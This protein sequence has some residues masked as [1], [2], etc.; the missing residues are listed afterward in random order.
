MMGLVGCLAALWLK[1]LRYPWSRLRQRLCEGRYLKTELPEAKSLQQIRTHLRKVTWT[2]DGFFHLWDALSYPETVWAKKKDDCDGFAVLAAELLERL[3]P[4]LNPVLVT[5]AVRP[6]KR[7]HTVCAFKDGQKFAFFDN[8]RLRKGD[9]QSY[10]D[11][12]TKFTSERSA[13]LLCWDVVKPKSYEML[14][15]HRA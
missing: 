14:E 3:H 6:L 12:V 7:S 13:K 9:Y 5:A 11:I 4:S 2:A 8:A 10:A 1:R 15:F